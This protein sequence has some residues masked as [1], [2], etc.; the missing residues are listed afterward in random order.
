MS[1]CD[2]VAGGSL[3]A[4]A[5]SRLALRAPALRAAT[6]LTR[7]KRSAQWLPCGRH[8]VP[9]AVTVSP[10][11]VVANHCVERGDHFAHDRHDRDL[12][13]F[14]R[15]LQT[16]VEGFERR[17]PITRAHRRHV[18]HLA[19]VG[20]TAPDAAPSLELTALEGIGRDVDQRRSGATSSLF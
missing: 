11:D 16:I 20:T 8:I 2:F 3:I 13:Q 19:N 18:E 7:P 6:A 5:A 15:G 9:T 10:S 14:A 17:I 4:L 1:N 12:R